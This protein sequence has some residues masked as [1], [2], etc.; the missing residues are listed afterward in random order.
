M[1]DLAVREEDYQGIDAMLARYRGRPPLSMRL[2]PA[3]ARSDAATIR[4]LLDEGRTLESR[5]LQ[6]AARYAA[7]YLEDFAL[8]ESLAVLDLTWRQ[9]PANRAGAELLLAGL[10]AARGRWSDA[11]HAYRTAETMEGAGAVVVQSAMSALMPFQPVADVD[12]R[13]LRTAVEQW[14][15]SAAGSTGLAAALQPHLRQYLLGLLSSRLRDLQSAERA[16]KAIEAL[17]GPDHGRGVASALAAT[18]RADVAWMQNR[19][20]DVMKALARTNAP[21]PLELISVSRAAHVREFGLEHARY[22]KAVAMTALGQNAEALA[23]LRFGFRGSPQ[24]YLYNGPVHLRL[25]EV[26]ERLDQPDSAIA[27]YRRFVDLW[28]GA[29]SG[30]TPLLNDVRGRMR[31]LGGG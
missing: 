28:S 24:E 17:P 22:L 8:A 19:P 26:F 6:I 21:I 1:W 18:I 29:D 31:R 15:P 13:S 5:Q 2:L 30:A 12:L 7:S 16:A 27:H 3:H 10:A 4:T 25:G 23:W 14:N 9:R 11:R 20:R